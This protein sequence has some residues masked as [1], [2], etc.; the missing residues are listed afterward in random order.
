MNQN[1][2]SKTDGVV[3]LKILISIF[4]N[5]PGQ[6]DNLLNSFVGMLLAELNVLLTKKKPDQ[7]YLSML[8]QAHAVAFY[9]NAVVTFGVCEQNQMTISLF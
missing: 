3:C 1:S 2:K 5:L 8:L 6:I 7:T 9:N 4:E